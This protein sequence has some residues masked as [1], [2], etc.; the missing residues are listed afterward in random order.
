MKISL[1]IRELSDFEV[2]LRGLPFSLDQR[3]TEQAL[4]K[5][6]EP[7][8]KYM[9][10]TAPVGRGNERV[11][12]NKRY[13]SNDYRRGGSTR[14]DIRVKTITDVLGEAKVLIGVSKA[15]GKVGWRYH[16]IAQGIAGNYRSNKG[17][18]PFVERA[19]D[20]MGGAVRA[21][22]VETFGKMALRAFKKY[23]IAA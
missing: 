12:L 4:R 6:A 23:K 19:G 20:V 13:R 7:L 16:F 8:R 22:F 3:L 5:S 1:D 21:D 9:A 17:P 15:S 10:A 2:Q 11:S 14:S 18:R